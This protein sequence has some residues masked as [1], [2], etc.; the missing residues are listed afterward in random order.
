MAASHA[1]L[2]GLATLEADIASAKKRLAAAKSLRDA[3]HKQYLEARSTIDALVFELDRLEK[4]R[5][6]VSA[7]D[8]T[9]A[10]QVMQQLG[11]TFDGSQ[12]WCGGRSYARLAD[13]ANYAR[14][15]LGLPAP[16]SNTAGR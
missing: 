8:A 3:L 11:I 14:V 10:R 6:S 12:Y 15:L 5:A 13:A 2:T 9:D 7:A 16:G 4:T 1:P